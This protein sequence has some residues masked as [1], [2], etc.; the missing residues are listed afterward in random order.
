MIN[1]LDQIK[2]AE[3][4]G[5]VADNAKVRLELVEKINAGIITH[6]QSLEELKKI[7]KQ[8]KKHGLLIRSD[9]TKN[10]LWDFDMVQARIIYL[11]H[12][13]MDNQIPVK[14]NEKK[15]INKI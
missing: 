8:G 13:K 9:F 3:D 5:I 12:E 11:L 7:K 15:I 10:K 6:E 1:V 4:L 2:K 14:E